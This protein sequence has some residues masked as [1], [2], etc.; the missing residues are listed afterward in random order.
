M[1]VI[2]E[3]NTNFCLAVSQIV[4]YCTGRLIVFPQKL[5]YLEEVSLVSHVLEE[6]LS[7][8]RAD[9]HGNTALAGAHGL[10]GRLGAPAARGALALGRDH[11]NGLGEPHQVHEQ[12]DG[13]ALQAEVHVQ[14]AGVHQGLQPGGRNRLL[15]LCMGR[16]T[17]KRRE[18]S[19]QSVGVELLKG[20]HCGRCI[21]DT[22]NVHQVQNGPFG[23]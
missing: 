1:S 23:I 21:I 9:H 17:R 6:S 16:K 3:K 4:L 2:F 5:C 11:G 8:W 15:A 19:R 22:P 14:A 10:L 20:F 18:R 13:H 7:E 12:G